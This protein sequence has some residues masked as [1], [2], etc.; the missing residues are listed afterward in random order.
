MRPKV[1]PHLHVFRQK[2]KERRIECFIRQHMEGMDATAPLLAVARCCASPMA[3]ALA[4][5]SDE[6]AGDGRLS[7]IFASDDCGLE[8]WATGTPAVGRLIREVRIARNPQLHDAHEQL[9]IGDRAIWWGDVLRRDPA[10]RDAFETYVADN[11]AEVHRAHSAFNRLWLATEPLYAPLSA[12]AA[13]SVGADPARKP[14]R[15]I[16]GA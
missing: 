9:M 16:A 6:L 1:P 4:A 8:S 13:A 15:G 3:R 5:V 14:Q 7:I 11:G 12:L 2:D 10:K